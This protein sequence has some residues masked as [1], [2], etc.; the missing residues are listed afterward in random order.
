MKKTRRFISASLLVGLSSLGAFIFG[1]SDNIEN[2]DFAERHAFAK[3]PARLAIAIAA[4]EE[5]TGAT[6][7][8]T[9]FIDEFE[10]TKYTIRLASGS[11][12][13]FT[14]NV[15]LSSTDII[16]YET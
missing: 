9:E 7:L 1:D 13:K 14:V 3:S 6:T 4:A 8:S 2:E 10:T 11:G 15:D 5:A 12:S 16:I